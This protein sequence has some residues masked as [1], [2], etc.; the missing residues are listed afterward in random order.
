MPTG[1]QRELGSPPMSPTG[2]GHYRAVRRGVP[3]VQR[4]RVRVGMLVAA[5]LAVIVFMSALR[6]LLE[7]RWP[8]MLF[9]SATC[10]MAIWVALRIRRTGA[11]R[12]PVAVFL[13]WMFS[14]FGVGF[15]A[16][17][18]FATSLT[19]W[20]AVL[21]LFALYMLGPRPGLIFLG[22]ALAE[23]GVAFAVY[24]AGLAFPMGLSPW[25]SNTRVLA[26]VVGIVLVGVIGYL[27]EAAQQ[28]TQAELQDALAAS[29]RNE[30][31]LDALVESATA[32]I[33]SI[34]RGLRLQV[35]NR[36]FE[37]MVGAKGAR[38]PRP[39]DPL[40]E[41]LP[42]AQW[43][44]W[45]PQIER[46]LAGAGP[47]TFEE[48]PP[49]GQDGPHRETMLQPIVAHGEVTGVT[50]FCRDITARK[51]AEAEMRQLNQEL[52]RMSRQAG[53]AVVA[54]E[55]LHNAG[56]VLNSTGVSVSMIDRHVRNLRIGHLTR[57]A[58][59]V[60]EHA[61]QLETFLRDDPRG[62][63]VPELLHALAEHFEQ[64]Q[65]QLGAEVTAL[66]S[67]I[68][69]FIRVIHAQQSHARGLGI[70]ETVSVAELIDAALD[71]QAASG[72]QLGIVIEREIGDV[73]LLHVDKHR[74]IEIL[75]NLI[76]NARHSLR[77]SGRPDKRLRIRAEAVV[78]APAE[79]AGPAGAG[80]RVRIHVEDNG[81]GIAS[82]HR[83]KLFRLGFTT[84]REGSGIG[85]HSSAN[86][87]Q[88]LGGS[89]SFDSD[90]PGQGAT[91][92]LELPVGE[93]AAA[94]AGPDAG[95][96]AGPVA[97]A[98]AGGGSS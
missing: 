56:N 94:A 96:D 77:D 73:P 51:R 62:Q 50:V 86:A 65:A 4:M 55:V 60:D 70:V 16:E 11:V 66:Q 67:S 42:P 52:V 85:L 32:A 19:A 54:G 75:V 44:R 6:A 71:L 46:V 38:E 78:A 69:H 26:A 35:H 24:R 92:T 41:I 98:D 64:Q 30:H 23:T 63:R 31:Q 97:A 84:R 58:T 57:L 21:A 14:L 13:A 76:S 40:S 18:G 83:D 91:F 9:S 17:G 93:A 47:V 20:P 1:P 28:R 43:A 22:V 87:A 10:A 49:P 7:G 29:E 34:D 15:C 33:C 82:E 81:L 88:Q 45:R 59:L 53:M 68:E 27:Y 90:G 79:G 2:V 12:T 95:P 74:V 48:S 89:L 36:A 61:G 37:A 5:G 39:N 80:E 8:V 25:D 72:S 3:F